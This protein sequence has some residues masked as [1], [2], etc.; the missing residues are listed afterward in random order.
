M[1]N[2]VVNYNYGFL[3]AIPV[4]DHRLKTLTLNKTF[5]KSGKLYISDIN[6]IY[7]EFENAG[8]IFLGKIIFKIKAA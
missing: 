7:K 1:I 6:I 3:H 8:T 4:A 2:V 5:E